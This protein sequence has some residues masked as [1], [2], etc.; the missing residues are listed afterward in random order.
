MGGF[1]RSSRPWPHC[2][3]ASRTGLP[4]SSMPSSPSTARRTPHD[5]HHEATASRQCSESG[6][7]THPPLP[8]DVETHREAAGVACSVRCAWKWSCELD[9]TDLPGPSITSVRP[10][11]FALSP[12]C[13]VSQRHRHCGGLKSIENA[14]SRD[15]YRLGQKVRTPRLRSP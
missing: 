8:S 6:V 13:T 10:A 15:L 2:R 12:H 9:L 4:S 7:Q 11:I 14:L 1:A 5:G 3:A